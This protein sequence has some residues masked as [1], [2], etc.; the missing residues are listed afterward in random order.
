MITADPQKTPTFVMFSDPNYYNITGASSCSSPCVF[1]APSFAWNHGD[2]QSDITTTWL[3]IVGPGVQNLGADNQVWSDHTD[4]RPT[5]LTLLGLHDDYSHQ[6]RALVDVMT[7]AAIPSGLSAN[8]ST[9]ESLMAIYK[10]INA[11]VGE[12]ALA[13]LAASN[14]ALSSGS[15][16]DDSQYTS[17]EA[18][19]AQITQS[20][21][22]LDA[23]IETAIEGATFHGQTLNVT[24]ANTLIAKAN[25]L[26][27][28]GNALGG[29]MTKAAR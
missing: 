13:T 11:P 1:E 21:N 4:I 5:M 20:R 10:Q 14:T 25:A 6:G 19:I 18:Q 24:Q 12:L 15:S 27:A 29:G 8:L 9:A 7:P 26:I 28:Q 23:Q 3:G 2:V 22:A 17:I 16:T